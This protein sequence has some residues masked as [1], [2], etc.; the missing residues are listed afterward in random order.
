MND[1]LSKP[2]RKATL[3]DAIAR[4]LGPADRAAE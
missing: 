4:Q 2:Y 1:F 3:F